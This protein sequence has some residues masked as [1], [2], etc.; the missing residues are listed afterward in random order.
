MAAWAPGRPA[1]PRRSA[2][3]T[4]PWPAL[5]VTGLVVVADLGSKAWVRRV[6]TQTSA[7]GHRWITNTGAAF[8]L[9]ADHPLAVTVVALLA[10]SAVGYWLLRATHPAER[11]LAGVVLGGAIGNLLDRVIHGGVTDWLSVPWYPATFNLADVAIRGGLLA[12]V[13]VGIVRRLRHR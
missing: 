9:G 10:T 1:P 12:A 13:T 5:A 11:L 7:T 8:G 4:R 3:A 6:P 2:A